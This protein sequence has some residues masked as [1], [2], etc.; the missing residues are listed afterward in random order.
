MAEVAQE[1]VTEGRNKDASTSPSTFSTRAEEMTRISYGWAL[2]YKKM[3]AW[4]FFNIF[5]GLALVLSLYSVYHLMVDIFSAQSEVIAIVVRSINTLVIALAMF[6][7]GAGIS[8][9]YRS[10]DDD[11]NIFINIRRTITRFVGT[12]CIALVLESLI[13]IIK[14]SQLDL[15]GN[16]YYPVAIMVGA[17]ILLICLG[18]FLGLTQ[19]H[20]E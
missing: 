14:Y 20:T 16:L 6:E 11:E 10:D 1:A 9:E 12:V 17:G 5:Y 2:L 8:K 19:G 3:M 7:L 4:L 13:M 18:G 15:A